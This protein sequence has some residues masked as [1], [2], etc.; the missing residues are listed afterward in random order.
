MAP[1]S[2]KGLTLFVADIRS[3]P[4]KEAEGR[5]VAKELAKIRQKISS[6]PPSGS[7]K[8]GGGIG[9]AMT[10]YDRKKYMWKLVYCYTLGYAVDI[11]HMEI[12]RLL[13]SS[14][15]SEKNAGYVSC[16]ILLSGGDN[17]QSKNE[18]LRLIVN[19]LKSELINSN[20]VY[21]ALAFNCIAN[22]G[23]QDMCENLM[24]DICKMVNPAAGV[25]VYIRRKAYMCM[26]K[27]F[28]FDYDSLPS[29]LWSKRLS[30]ALQNERDIGCLTS[31]VSL[32]I[33]ILENTDYSDWSIIQTS[34]ISCLSRITSGDVP[35]SYIYYT[36]PAPW[37]QMK[38]LRLLQFFPPSNDMETL[39]KQNE[40]IHSMLSKT[41]AGAQA[42][43]ASAATKKK[44]RSDQ[45]LVNKCNIEHGV[46][47]EAMN[48]GIHLENALDLTTKKLAAAALGA[49]V[50]AKEANIRY[51]GLETMA[52]MAFDPVIVNT[53]K[54]HTSAILAQLTEPDISIRRQALNLLYGI[55]DKDNWGYIV[56]QLLDNL[57]GADVLLQ[58]EL[59]L[60]IAILVEKNAPDFSWYVDVVLKMIEY[61]PDCV[62]DDIWFRV[63]Q[64]VTGFDDGTDKTELQTYAAQKA[65]DYLSDKY[66]DETMVKLGAYLLGEFGHHI[67]EEAPPKKQMAML[68]KHFSR[69][70]CNAR[71]LLLVAYAKLANA[72]PSL[73]ANVLSIL[74]DCD[75]SQDAE[76]QT[77]A[78]ELALV[79]QSD[80]STMEKTLAM[81]P[82]F[83][84]RVQ[85]N[86]PL[87][88][89][90]KLAGKSR[91]HSR[92]AI[93][94]A[95]KTTGGLYKTVG[96]QGRQEVDEDD[97]DE[98]TAAA[99]RPSSVESSEVS[100]SS[101]TSEEGESGSSRSASSESSNSSTSSTSDEEEE[102]TLPKVTDVKGMWKNLCVSKQGHLYVSSSLCV[103]VVSSEYR[104]SEG[105]I[106]L[107][108]TNRSEK[109]VVAVQSVT[110]QELPA[111]RVRTAAGQMP[112]GL[113][114]SPGAVCT[115][116]LQVIAMQPFLN[117]PRY[118]V[119]AA[120]TTNAGTEALRLPFSLPIVLSKFIVPAN[121]SSE[122]FQKFW[123]QLEGQPN[124]TP[125]EMTDKSV[126]GAEQFEV[127][128]N[129]AFNLHTLKIGRALCGAGTFHTATPN[130]NQPGKMV[131]VAC[132]CKIEQQDKASG[133][134]GVV[135]VSVRAAHA[136]VGASLLQLLAAYFFNPSLTSS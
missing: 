83:S 67:T 63:V 1:P 126:I 58:E 27:L 9:S 121:L 35:P 49:F 5:R 43:P 119:V 7:G 52:R 134:G 6:A 12:I 114:L 33:G 133:R 64:V 26:L 68:H 34:A 120:I 99:R 111:V 130:E 22:V 3:C 87:I 70:S 2:M 45:D 131:C 13:S 113:S 53:L 23:T 104:G 38:L 69:V 108:F 89:R 30:M 65:Y 75:D 62:S 17:V 66:C 47:F 94:E 77:R 21:S 132:M 39:T 85:A 60:K 88:R 91:A 8:T 25:R 103:S 76:L 95:T 93:E 101:T 20:D 46:L 57:K 51:L 100:N 73:H 118:L 4:T 42:E 107:R 105:K 127:Y 90:M 79:L 86:N 16:S 123:A 37:L 24:T 31:V 28:R 19:L 122:V 106:T 80:E 36:V 41:T 71:A 102:L 56:D 82:T 44:K 59:V 109:A 10:G 81:M 32:L 124:T 40:L 115:H 55:C 128:L 92:R 78:C 72:H 98:P 50:S 135:R 125:R 84:E 15:Y 110:I 112:T 18:I 136:P 116:Q 97:R 48:L 29:D 14:K 96:P 54:K 61:A 129:K 117:P 11:A 74:R